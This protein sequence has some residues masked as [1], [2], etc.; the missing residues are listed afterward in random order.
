MRSFVNL[1]AVDPGFDPDNV[2]TMQLS[3]GAFDN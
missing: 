2:L 3:P 1:M